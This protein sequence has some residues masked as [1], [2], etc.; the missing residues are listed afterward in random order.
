MND[1][2][3]PTG[4]TGHVRISG[5]RDKPDFIRV[6][7]PTTKENIETYVARPFVQAAAHHGFLPF[8]VDGEPKQNA[9]DDFDFTLQTSEGLKYLELMEIHLGDLV[10]ARET[11]GPSSYDLYD[12]AR[13]VLEKIDGKS[14]RYRG[15]TEKGIVLLT[16]VTHWQFN[17]DTSALLALSYWLLSNPPVFEQV[18]YMSFLDSQTVS[19]SLVYPLPIDVFV[20][21]DPEVYRGRRVLNMDP[22]AWQLWNE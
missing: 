10:L 12:A 9:I 7:F 21:F 19:L 4:D 15:A 1:R 3:K 17:L 22:D 5:S 16:Y 14:G 18:Y 13:V 8:I 6:P 20:G 11:P 2:R